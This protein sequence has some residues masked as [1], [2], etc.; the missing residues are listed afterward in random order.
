[1]APAWCCSLT[2]SSSLELAEG[3]EQRPCVETVRGGPCLKTLHVVVCVSVFFSQ[4]RAR[5]SLQSRL[6]QQQ[7]VRSLQEGEGLVSV[8][9]L[10]H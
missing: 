4:S 3:W 5:S 1:M 8:Q 10:E 6:Q 7:D 2:L 9:S